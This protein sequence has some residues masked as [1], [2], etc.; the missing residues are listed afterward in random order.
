MV[1]SNVAFHDL[2]VTCIDKLGHLFTLRAAFHAYIPRCIHISPL[3]HAFAEQSVSIHVSA[4]SYKFV[5]AR[6]ESLAVKCN[7]MKQLYTKWDKHFHNQCAAKQIFTYMM[8]PRYINQTVV[9]TRDRRT[10]S[11]VPI[12]AITEPFAFW[13][14]WRKHKHIFAFYIIHQQLNVLTRIVRFIVKKD[15][16]LMSF[17]YKDN[18]H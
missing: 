18:N 16:I 3:K 17:R 6:K 4:K 2:A 13:R 15:S 1:S 11:K 7:I 14:Y 5:R 9:T 12:I 10:F 8:T